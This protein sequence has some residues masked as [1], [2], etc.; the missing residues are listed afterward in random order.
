MV[1]IWGFSLVLM[2]EAV[3]IHRRS[4]RHLQ[5]LCVLVGVTFSVL[6][7]VW[8]IGLLIILP[9]GLGHALL[10]NVWTSAYPLVL[11]TTLY[12]MASV[13]LGGAGLGLRALGAARLSLRA[14]TVTSAIYVIA[15]VIGAAAAGA[16]G[17]VCGGAAAMGAG[18]LVYWWAFRI[19]LREPSVTP[20]PAVSRRESEVTEID[21]L[22]H[23]TGSPQALVP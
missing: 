14:T 12:V 19:A 15:S 4:P 18:A 3:R 5:H 16:L 23:A 2:P 10:G 9:M 11:P 7:A 8:G 22:D 6:A 17:A 21:Q 1:M 13:T 20:A